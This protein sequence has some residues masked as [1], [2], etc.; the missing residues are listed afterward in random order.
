MVAPA[1][2]VKISLSE[3]LRSFT[4]APSRATARRWIDNR[5]IRGVRIGNSYYVYSNWR[6]EEKPDE[7]INDFIQRASGKMRA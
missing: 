1:D 4:G 6:I 2:E 7:Q 5:I 3:W